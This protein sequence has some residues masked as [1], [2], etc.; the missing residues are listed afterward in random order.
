MT[1]QDFLREKTTNVYEYDGTVIDS[2][3]GEIL[4]HE[5]TTKKRTSSEPDYIKL[6][7][8]TMMAV[9][10]VDQIPL[11][12]IL[13]LSAQVNYANGDRMLFYNNK[14]T[15]RAIADYCKCGDNWTAKLIKASVD[16]GIL[17]KTEDRGTYEVNPWLIAKGKWE[18]I[19]ALQA[20]FEFVS[21]KWQRIIAVDQEEGEV[22][23]Q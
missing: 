20:N 4:H 9:Q 17:F 13:A 15:R 21:G 1:E 16:K 7:Y 5:H 11:D 19:K 14:T 3:T 2:Q 18:N 10:D 22:N 6:Y 12:F 23:E 8:K